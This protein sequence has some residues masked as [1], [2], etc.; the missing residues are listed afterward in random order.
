MYPFG[1]SL[2]VEKPSIPILTT[3]SV[4]YPS[5]ECIM[6]FYESRKKGKLF[7][8]GSWQL[9]QDEYF[10]KEDNKKIFTFILN[11]LNE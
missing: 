6:S 5:N 4:S 3:G 10:E 8:L 9:F 2:N 11:N 1:S 7:V